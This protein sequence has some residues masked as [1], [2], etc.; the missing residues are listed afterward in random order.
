MADQNNQQEHRNTADHSRLYE[1]VGELNGRL[2]ACE[3]KIM[4]LEQEIRSELRDLKESNEK[5]AEKLQQIVDSVNHARGGWRV[6]SVMGAI[7]VVV[8][9][10]A[11]WAFDHWSK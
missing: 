8:I 10:L 11:T 6:L 5:M 2:Q 3:S 4:G 1:K 9:G 7:F